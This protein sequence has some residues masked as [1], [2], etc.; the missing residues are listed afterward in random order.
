MVLSL[1]GEEVLFVEI[2]IC[3]YSFE[4]FVH[5]LELGVEFTGTEL[6]VEFALFLVFV[7]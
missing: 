1:Q 2:A 5:K 3:F 4:V 6:E 7:G